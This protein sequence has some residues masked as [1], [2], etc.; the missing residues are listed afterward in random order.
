MKKPDDLIIR[1]A[2]RAGIVRDFIRLPYRLYRSHRCWVPPL[3]CEEKRMFSRKRNHFLGKNPVV[4]YVCYRGKIPVGRIAGI[5][6]KEHNR[7]HKDKVAF[8]G[9]FECVRD[10]PAAGQ[11]FRAV[12]RWVQDNGADVLRGPTNFTLNEVSGLLIDGFDEPP[13]IMMP[14]NPPYYEELYRKNGFEIAMRFFAYDATADSARFP[15]AA[16]KVEKRLRDNGLT[17]RNINLKNL[18]ADVKTFIDM[19]NSTW[20]E[21]WGFIP[22]SVEEAV[23]DFRKVKGFAK[24]DLLLMALYKGQPAGFVIALPDIHQAIKPLKGRLLPF[25]WIKLLRNLE[26]ID[27]IRV[28]LMGIRKEFRSKGIDLVLYKKILENGVRHN[29]YRAELSW[30][31]E[32]NG[33]M[34]QVLQHI[35]AKKNKTYA[36]FEKHL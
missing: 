3:L 8:F 16:D 4:L 1:E 27:Q 15:A 23:E 32:N 18:A 11:L 30:V 31:L 36:I 25:N 13:F 10:D 34:N 14:Y 2:N 5:I 29:Y 28:V 9:F 33:M 6:N 22:A 7:Y 35:N 19:F 24:W 26:K 20:K 21:N 17:I 12:S